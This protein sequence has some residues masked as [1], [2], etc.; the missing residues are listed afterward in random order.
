MTVGGGDQKVVEVER[1][2]ALFYE[3]TGGTP[4]KKSTFGS[5]ATEEIFG[6]RKEKHG[7]YDTQ[8]IDDASGW[9]EASRIRKEGG[10]H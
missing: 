8:S 6:A 5:R 2:V 1:N 9:T 4:E 3:R 10:V 7:T